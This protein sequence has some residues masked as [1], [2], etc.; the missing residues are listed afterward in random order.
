[1]KRIA[2]ILLVYLLSVQLTGCIGQHA[3]EN[4]QSAPTYSES[5][6]ESNDRF[7]YLE[8]LPAAKQEAIAKFKAER[9]LQFLYDFT[10]EDMVIVYL[11]CLSIGDP[12]LLYDIAYNGGELPDRDTF[13]EEYYTYAGNHGSETAVH[14]RH[15][16]SIEVDPRTAEE[17]T[18]TVLVTTGVGTITASMA[19]GLRQE[20]KVW[21]VDI[22][23]WIAHHKEQAKVDRRL[24][25]T[26]GNVFNPRTIQVGDR[27]GNFTLKEIQVFPGTAD[28]PYDTLTA[29]FEGKAVLEGE[30]TYIGKDGEFYT[31]DYLVFRPNMSSQEKLPM[32]HHEERGRVIT[33]V[34]QE[35]V[36]DAANIQPG[37][38][39]AVKLEI[40]NYI[41]HFLP[42][43][44]DNVA[45]FLTLLEED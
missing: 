12:D 6:E 26:G 9:N 1:M 22:Y 19:L 15:Y 16:E 34:N 38:S 10:P 8:Q 45:T 24:P 21:K 33:F 37:E 40:E 29:K 7:S 32:S 27:V 28:Y 20:D 41:L 13:R 36:V 43:D 31:T 17:D 35:D 5:N 14:Y 23:H 30:L 42:T 39:Q 3:A 2:N 11:Y 18:L 4:D 25:L 44:A